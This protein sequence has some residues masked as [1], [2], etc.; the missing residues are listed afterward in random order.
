MILEDIHSLIKDYRKN[1]I[2]KKNRYVFNPLND[3]NY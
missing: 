2:D 1:A 3:D